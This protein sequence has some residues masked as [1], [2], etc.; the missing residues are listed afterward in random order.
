VTGS[1]DPFGSKLFRE[2]LFNT[3]GKDFPNVLFNLQTNGVMFTPKYWDK[4]K[5]TNYNL[6]IEGKGRKQYTGE[7]VR[8]IV[9][10]KLETTYDNLQEL[11]TGKLKRISAKEYDKLP[12][13][14]KIKWER[15]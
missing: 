3:N 10:E 2:F 13:K 7:Q 4:M 5:D 12:K 9:A 6:D 11:N 14:E 1:G 8:D 15:D